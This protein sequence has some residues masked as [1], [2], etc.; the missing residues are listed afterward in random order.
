MT[1]V[2]GD[3]ARERD[4]QVEVQT[5]LITGALVGVQ[6]PHDVDLFGDL[7]LAGEGVHRLDGPRLDRREPVQ[8]EHLA[9][10]V[11][12]GLFGDAS[13]GQELGEAG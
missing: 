6:T 2:L 11:E 8:L 7:S 4:G 5:Q 13:R 12:D 9:Q 1:G 10:R 3:V